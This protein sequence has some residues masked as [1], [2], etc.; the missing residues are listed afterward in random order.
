MDELYA[1]PV[2][3]E[4]YLGMN[5]GMYTSVTCSDSGQYEDLGTAIDE[6]KKLRPAFQEVEL[7]KEQFEICAMWPKSDKRATTKQPVTSAIPALSLGGEF[8]PVT[9]AYWAEQAS[10]TLSQSHYLLMKA[11]A[12]GSMDACSRDIKTAFLDDPGKTPDPGCSDARTL[13]FITSFAEAN[14]FRS[15]KRFT[16][17]PGPTSIAAAIRPNVIVRP[18]RGLARG[19]RLRVR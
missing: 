4:K 17:R 14:S 7:I 9:P 18:A 12:H 13:T 1:N 11:L 3:G 6:V 5:D 19:A 8:D 15:A 2:E 10:K 16:A